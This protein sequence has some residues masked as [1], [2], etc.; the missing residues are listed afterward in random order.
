MN[1]SMLLVVPAL[2]QA[3]R[4]GTP[5]MADLHVAP[6]SL[7]RQGVALHRHVAGLRQGQLQHEAAAVVSDATHDVQA[8]G[9]PGHVHRILHTLAQPLRTPVHYLMA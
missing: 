4:V 2:A 3:A 1:V 9:S 7:A 5:H 6:D 8:P